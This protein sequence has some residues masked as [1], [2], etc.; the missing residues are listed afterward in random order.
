M[1]ARWMHLGAGETSILYTMEKMTIAITQHY[2]M[3]PCLLTVRNNNN[4]AIN[5]LIDLVPCGPVISFFL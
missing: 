4:N 3:H 1:N 2:A 5:A